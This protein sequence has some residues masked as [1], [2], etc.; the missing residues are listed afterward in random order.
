MGRLK[1]HRKRRR[2]VEDVPTKLTDH[3]D[4]FVYPPFYKRRP[5]LE[6]EVDTIIPYLAAGCRLRALRHAEDSLKTARD[7][8]QWP[9]AISTR[10]GSR[11]LQIP[12]PKT[13]SLKPVT[14]KP[15][16]QTQFVQKTQSPTPNPAAATTT[17]QQ[18]QQ[19]QQ[20]KNNH[21]RMTS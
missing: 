16:A 13:L 1:L 8:R 12:N 19:Q 18:K 14:Q 10:R 4:R 15:Y 9:Q 11:R 7:R 2:S 20:Q 3:K 21:N 17:K 6:P 5:R